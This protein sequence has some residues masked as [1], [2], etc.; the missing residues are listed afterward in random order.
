MDRGTKPHAPKPSIGGALR[1]P[2]LTQWVALAAFRGSL[3]SEAA[4]WSSRGRVRTRGFTASSASKRS[5]SD[6]GRLHHAAA[7]RHC[8]L[9]PLGHALQQ[10]LGNE[11]GLLGLRQGSCMARGAGLPGLT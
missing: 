7:K 9:K 6:A 10:R 11:A 2:R 4:A 3:P 8:D 1:H 5:G